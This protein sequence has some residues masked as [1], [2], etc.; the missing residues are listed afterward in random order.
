M[1]KLLILNSIFCLISVQSAYSAD[2]NKVQDA[3]SELETVLNNMFDYRKHYPTD[4]IAALKTCSS[5]QKLTDFKTFIKQQKINGFND[6]VCMTTEVFYDSEKNP[7]TI[8]EC[9]YP[10][11]ELSKVVLSFEALHTGTM[12]KVLDKEPYF[13]IDGA[14]YPDYT[15]KYCSV[16][17]VK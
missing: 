17:E 6:N 14:K 5:Y 8:M 9:N 11:S 13:L 3:P 4:F 12:V 1:K 10:K 2:K 7:Q 15:R 16:S